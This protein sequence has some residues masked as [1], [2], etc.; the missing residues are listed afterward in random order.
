MMA[1][2]R[3]RIANV[4][5]ALLKYMLFRDEAPLKGPV[6]GTS[7]F[8]KEF[9]QG[10]PRDSKRRSLRELDLHQ[11]LLRFPC[12]YLIYSEAFGSLP[13]EAKNYLWRRLVEILSGKDQSETYV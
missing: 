4:S 10:G 9:Q 6:K 11:R 1:A 13:H 3:Q 7:A 12:S 2:T 5:E 8:A